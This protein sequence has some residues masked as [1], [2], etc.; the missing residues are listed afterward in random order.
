MMLQ[1]AVTKAPFS[2]SPMVA[3]AAHAPALAAGFLPAF[4]HEADGQVRLC[5]TDDGRLSSVHLLDSLPS[6][7]VAERDDR[8]R[9]VALVDQVSAGYLRGDQFWGLGELRRPRLD[10]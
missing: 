6:D 2:H 3:D 5:L 4:R 7:W 9:P 8:G 10:S 1:Q